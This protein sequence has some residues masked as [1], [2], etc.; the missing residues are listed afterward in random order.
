MQLHA[1]TAIARIEITRPPQTAYLS[2]PDGEVK[3]AAHQLRH[4]PI[5][6]VW[7]GV[8]ALGCLRISCSDI[9]LLRVLLY[10]LG[11]DLERCL[12]TRWRPGAASVGEL[13]A[14]YPLAASRAALLPGLTG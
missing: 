4:R 10:L 12:R 8:G 11:L 7:S 6:F 2:N 9:E 3:Q 5:L 14:W 1:M 13:G